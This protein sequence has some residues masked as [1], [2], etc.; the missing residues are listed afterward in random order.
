MTDDQ[1]RE[2]AHEQWASDDLEF[3]ADARVIHLDEPGESEGD[4]W[5]QAW[6]YVNRP[7]AS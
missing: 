6:V 7:E 2:R 3:D 5:V 1:A 4:A